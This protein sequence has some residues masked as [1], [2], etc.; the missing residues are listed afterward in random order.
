MIS[1]DQQNRASLEQILACETV[2]ISKFLCLGPRRGLTIFEIPSHPIAGFVDLN[3]NW[4]HLLKTFN[5]YWLNTHWYL[6]AKTSLIP[7]LIP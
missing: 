3:T 4:L 2:F 5:S 7:S 1:A 6:G